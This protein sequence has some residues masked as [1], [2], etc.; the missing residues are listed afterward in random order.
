MSVRFPRPLAPGDVIA[1]TAPS[2]GVPA[3]LVPRLDV[4]VSALRHRGFDVRVGQCV[5]DR[6]GDRHGEIVSAPAAERAAELQDMLLDPAV[7]AIVP[8]W[9]DGLLL[10]LEAGGDGAA[11]IARDLWRMRLAGWFDVTCAVLVGRTAAP[12]HGRFTQRDT[13]FSAL[14]GLDV[15][16]VLD[17]DC[18]HGPPH[19]AL[20][21][22][23]LTDLVVDPGAGQRSLVQHLT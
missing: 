10:H 21:E 3:A 17:V 4:A 12:D 19:L 14:A 13:I 9:G 23:A 8:P 7:R 1:V 6:E 15:P 22:G 20:V 5:V 11:D 2:S 18:G 16:V